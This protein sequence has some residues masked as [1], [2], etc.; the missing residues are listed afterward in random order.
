MFK[1]IAIFPVLLLAALALLA[2]G[3]GSG[4]DAIT[5]AEYIEQAEKI[6]K[7][8]NRA[9]AR[10]FKTYMRVNLE[11]IKQE[12][13][14]PKNVRLI[15]DLVQDIRVPAIMSELEQLEALE[16]PEED[17]KEVEEIF[18]GTKKGA[19]ELNAEPQLH[20]ASWAGNPLVPSYQQ[21]HK[22]GFIAC[23]ES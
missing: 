6:C 20:W 21:A 16:I 4:D 15:N 5:K 19:E 22:Y 13:L 12:P 2:T 14:P 1:R 3:C 18:A 23:A 17:R 8:N 10:E 11:R 7:D 9:E